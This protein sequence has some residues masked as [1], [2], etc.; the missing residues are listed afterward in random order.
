MGDKLEEF[1]VTL[2]LASVAGPGEALYN[3][4]TALFEL[5]RHE[6]KVELA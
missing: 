4:A 1:Y 3:V 2:R 6:C 5:D